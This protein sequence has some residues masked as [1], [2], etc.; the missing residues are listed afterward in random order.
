MSNGKRKRKCNEDGCE[1][2]HKARGLCAKHY[3]NLPDVIEAKKK[4]AVDNIEKKRASGRRWLAANKERK[5]EY[6]R[7]WLA[8]N[9][10]R[11]KNN[12]ARWRAENEAREK[13]NDRKWYSKNRERQLAA[14]RRWLI[15]NKERK[16]ETNRR[17]LVENKGAANAITARRRFRKFQATPGWLSS[18]HSEQIKL[19][20]EAAA[21]NAVHVDHIVPLRGEDV[22]GLHVPWNLQLL[23]KVSNSNKGNKL[24]K[25]GEQ[26]AWMPANLS[27]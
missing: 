25:E 23:D 3:N 14:T 7:R 13:D 9:K 20:Y 24:T 18:A 21:A 26:L 6:N 2:I 17:W 5:R 1:A 11:Q 10:E 22:C 4:W 16:K 8:D 19:F 15:E 12:V 27:T